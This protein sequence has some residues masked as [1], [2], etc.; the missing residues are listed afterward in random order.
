MF[1]GIAPD[2][3]PGRCPALL[4]SRSMCA[5]PALQ[6]CGSSNQ[7]IHDPQRPTFGQVAPLLWSF[8]SAGAASTGTNHTSASSSSSSFCSASAPTTTLLAETGALSAH[9]MSSASGHSSNGGRRMPPSIRAA[10]AGGTLATPVLPRSSPLRQRE[11]QQQ[12]GQP[13]A[14]LLVAHNGGFDARMLIGECL[15]RGL[16]APREWRWV[17]SLGSEAVDAWC[18]GRVLGE[19]LCGLARLAPWWRM[20]DTAC[21]PCAQPCILCCAPVL[22]FCVLRQRWP[23]NLHYV[24]SW[25]IY[26]CL[27]AAGYTALGA[28]VPGRAPAQLQA[29]DPPLSFWSDARALRGSARRGHRCDCAGAAAAAPAAGEAAGHVCGV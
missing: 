26:P 27:Q 25:H 5:C 14:P 21:M 22:R 23:F 13:E 18:T 17:A 7:Q 3:L 2:P 19:R 1:S 16:G 29:G 15:R 4:L 12:P 9:S 8:F 24:H 10:R 6:V 20:V 11:M 28:P